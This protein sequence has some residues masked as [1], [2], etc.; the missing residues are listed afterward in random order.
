MSAVLG[1]M[2]AATHDALVAESVTFL[3]SALTAGDP[4][5]RAALRRILVQLEQHETV[6]ERQQ[7]TAFPIG[8]RVRDQKSF[9]GTV[10]YVGPVAAAK[11]ARTIYVGVEWDD[12]TRGKH[13]GEVTTADGTTVRHFG[14]TAAKTAAS[15]V[16]PRTLTLPVRHGALV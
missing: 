1:M 16:K 8:S 4:L 11:N 15:F 12:E 13:D 6:H 3:T 10:R 7:D 2:S 9:Y 5:D 14:P